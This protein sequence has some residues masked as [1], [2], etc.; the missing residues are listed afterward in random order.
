LLVYF[1]CEEVLNQQEFNPNPSTE[2]Q[3]Q[4]AT[5]ENQ[6]VAEGP[7]SNIGDVA[8][9]KKSGNMFEA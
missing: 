1:D 6:P 7:F 5:W 3:S 9:T 8:S 2:E 4:L